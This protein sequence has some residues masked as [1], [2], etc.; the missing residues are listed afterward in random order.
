MSKKEVI[1]DEALVP[2]YQLPSLLGKSD[3]SSAATAG[4]WLS[5]RRPEILAI[6]RERVF[7]KWLHRP[8]IQWYE[9]LSV[10]EDALDG[11]AI[12]K[13]IRIHL[14]SAEGKTHSFDM[15]LYIPKTAT[16]EHPVPVFIGLNFRGNHATTDERDVAMTGFG[17]EKNQYLN[18]E[19]RGNSVPRWCFRETI[20]RGYASATICYH[21]ICPDYNDLS[22]FRQS[23]LSILGS[24]DDLS[25]VHRNYTAIGLWA[26]GLSRGLDCLESEVL[27][28]SS[29]CAVHGLSRLGKTSLWAGANDERFK[30]VISTDSGCGGAALFKRCFGETAEIISTAFPHWFV[31]A[32]AQ[33]RGREDLMDFDQHFLLSLIAPRALCV[34]SATE[35]LWADPLGEFLA[36]KHAGDAYR[37]FGLSGIESDDMPAA[38]EWLTGDVSYHLRTGKHD[39]TPEDWAHYWVLADRIFQK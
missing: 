36:A 38:D 28:D 31:E 11:E 17:Y 2:S 10:R 8:Q 13:E 12:R 30:L 33:Y 18:D 9:T 29:R 27:V 26:W 20:R 6:Y 37:L 1:Y 22:C 39:Q 34:A 4:E 21:D 25:L 5:T 35:D 3:G 7:G 32:F 14:G 15:L 23:V 19:S 24:T 16:P